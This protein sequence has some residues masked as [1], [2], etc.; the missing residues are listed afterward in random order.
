MINGIRLKICGLTSLVDAEMA[1]RAGADYLGFNLYAKSPRFVA[2]EQFRTMAPRLPDRRKVAVT[3]DPTAA[4]LREIAAAGFDFIQVHFEAGASPAGAAAWA[5]EAGIGR[6]WLAPRLPPEADIPP[7]VLSLAGTF[8]FDAFAADRFGGSGKTADWAKF[9]RHREAHSDKT[10]IL[11]GGLNPG[12]IDVAL[13]VTGAR[14]VDVNSGVESAPGV[15]DQAK[16]AALVAR[17]A[18]CRN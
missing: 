11:A 9:R 15:K 2:L 10:W 13:M 16:L 14:F 12:N 17:L 8:L 6:L 1:D 3:V 4:E 7:A 5:A 18:E